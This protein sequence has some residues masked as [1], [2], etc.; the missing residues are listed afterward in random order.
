MFPKEGEFLVEKVTEVQNQYVYVELI[1]YE[2]LNHEESQYQRV[3]IG[4]HH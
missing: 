2:E 4:F 1:D 3:N